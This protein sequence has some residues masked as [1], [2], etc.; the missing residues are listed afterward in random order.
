MFSVCIDRCVGPGFGCVIAVVSS[1][2]GDAAVLELTTKGV[3]TWPHGHDSDHASWIVC[4]TMAM[5]VGGAEALPPAS[6]SPVSMATFMTGTSYLSG[7]SSSWWN[8]DLKQLAIAGGS[9]PKRV[10]REPEPDEDED[11]V[12]DDGGGD[13]DYVPDDG[14]ADEDYVADDG[15]ADD[16]VP[17]D[18]GDDDDDS[19]GGLE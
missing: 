19:D 4:I 5:S 16:Y 14:G 9:I 13:D 7:C 6:T 17:D 11:Y 15:G 2:V 12:P 1:K 8:W 18:G 10:H 3:I